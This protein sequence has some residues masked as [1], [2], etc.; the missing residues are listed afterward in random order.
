MKKTLITG[1]TGGLG[2]TVVKFLK[3][4]N[5][6][7][8]LAVLVRDE[9]SD[10]AKQYKND[11]I[12]VRIG[13]YDNIETLENAF[14]DIEVLYFV[15]GSDINHRL[16]QHK[17]V[18]TAAKKAGVKHILYT[19]TVRK[20]ENSSAPLYPVVNSH[21]QTEDL[22]IASGLKYT[23]LRHNLYAEVIPMFIGDKTQLLQ[24]KSIYLPTANGATAFVPRKDFAEAEAIILEDVSKYENKTLEFNGSETITFSEISKL[25]SETINETITYISPE[26]AE[27]R[28]KMSAVGLPD[29]IIDMLSMFSLGIA[30]TEF[31][32]Q[33]NDLE[34]VLGRKTQPLKDFLKEVY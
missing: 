15:S 20:D 34:T 19:S 6:L 4:K 7:N 1:A 10:L 5:N 12:E 2:S 25:L 33:T 17:N 32:Q 23:I 30:N 28:T 14:K 16:P 13:D 11:G 29:F 18:V 27:F 26:D 21:K 8:H 31:N 9:N 3:E 24:T 22:I